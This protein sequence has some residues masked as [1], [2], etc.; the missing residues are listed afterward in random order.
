MD[1]GIRK[2]VSSG[3]VILSL[4]A[5]LLLVLFFSI[6]PFVDWADLFRV[7]SPQARSEAGHVLAVSATCFALNISM[8][9]VQRVQLGLKQGYRYGLWQLVGNLAG[10][11]GFCAVSGFM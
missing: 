3:F 4:I 10:F 9:V 6:Y 11:A 7:V 5:A 1:V 2:A 8:D